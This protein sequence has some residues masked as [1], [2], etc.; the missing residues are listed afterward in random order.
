MIA[1]RAASL[2]G[3]V[4]ALV[5]IGAC[6]R[7]GFEAKQATQVDGA[8]SAHRLEIAHFSSLAAGGVDGVFG[9]LRRR[10]VFNVAIGIVSVADVD[11]VRAFANSCSMSLEVIP[12]DS[13]SRGPTRPRESCG[14]VVWRPAEVLVSSRGVSD[15][16]RSEVTGFVVRTRRA[17]DPHGMLESRVFHIRGRDAERVASDVGR[18][19]ELRERRDR[20]PFVAVATTMFVDCLDE[21]AGFISMD[22][23]L[24]ALDKSCMFVNSGPGSVAAPGLRCDRGPVREF[25]VEF[26]SQR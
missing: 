26:E 21:G 20:Q 11:R 10:T 1:R 3:C 9:E 16:Q 24:D 22:R 25:S 23:N 2:C 13:E 7:A 19:E 14:V 18:I 4:A 12:E 15:A 17:G 5:G 6:F 8:T